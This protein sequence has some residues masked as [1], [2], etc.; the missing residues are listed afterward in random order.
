MDKAQ[1]TC[2][3]EAG[4]TQRQIATEMGRSQ[5]NVRHWL[6]KHGLK[7]QR[8]V[9]TPELRLPASSDVVLPPPPVVD[10]SVFNTS[11]TGARTEARVLAALTHADYSCY[12]PFGIGRAD[13]VIETS[14]GLKSIQV[15]TGAVRES[16]AILAFKSSSVDRH[17]RHQDYRGVVDF[18]AV[19]APGLAGVFLLPV[20]EVSRTCVHLRLMPPRNNQVSRTHL[21]KHYLIPGSDG[22]V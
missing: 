18:F 10:D 12:V 5:T 21:A 3:V 8:K 13:L 22:A 20:D 15:K 11:R 4:M 1:M 2:L 14:D 6:R 7:T 16:G 17:G 19:A 9:A